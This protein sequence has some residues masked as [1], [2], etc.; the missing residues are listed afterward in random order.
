MKMKL[1][2]VLLWF[3]A[4]ASISDAQQTSTT[5]PS[6]NSAVA[7]K[8]LDA[9]RAQSQ[10]FVEAFNKADAKAIAQLWTVDGEYVDDAGTRFV[11]R[12]AIEK[13]YGEFFTSN[14]GTKITVN[15][16]GLTQVSSNVVIEDGR[17]VAD[18]VSPNAGVSK[19]VAVH[20]NVD[21]AW[22]MASVRDTWIEAPAAVQSGGDLAWL[23]GTWK[24][25]EHGIS[26]ESHCRWIADGHFIERSFTNTAFDGTKSSSVQVIGWNAAQGVVQSWDFS[27]EG[28][29]AVGNWVPAENGW[30]AEMRGITGSGIPTSSVSI[31]GR[32]DDNAYVWQSFQ[33]TVGGVALPDTD[34]VILKRQPTTK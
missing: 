25:E 2:F 12:E 7:S 18:S 6:D 24:G 13:A 34:E 31:L 16:D 15:I 22:L 19:Y 4:T 3:I 29:H 33:R 10:A 26:T 21:G 30:V 14:P 28:G 17:A 20:A 9:V 27:A 5:Q 11:G 8:E 23:I 32:L 1:V